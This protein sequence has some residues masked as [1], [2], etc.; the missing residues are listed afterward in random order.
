MFISGHVSSELRSLTRRSFKSLFKP[1]TKTSYSNL[2]YKQYY[3]FSNDNK[4]ND[5]NELDPKNYNQIY[6]GGFESFAAKRRA[7]AKYIEKMKEK[8]FDVSIFAEGPSDIVVDFELFMLCEEKDSQLAEALM[9]YYKISFKRNQSFVMGEIMKNKVSVQ[10]KIPINDMKFPML[11]VRISL[12][13][14]KYLFGSQEILKYLTKNN[15]IFEP[16]HLTQS[17]RAAQ[18]IEFLRKDFEKNLDALFW[19]PVLTY[20]N[21]FKT[22]PENYRFGTRSFFLIRVIRKTFTKVFFNIFKNFGKRIKNKELYKSSREN[23]MKNLKEWSDRIGDKPFHGGE[24]PD[25]ADFEMFA[26]IKAKLNSQYF[27]KFLENK[28]PDRVY[29]WLLRM[30]MNCRFEPGR[31]ILPDS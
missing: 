15:F 14:A 22:A 29:R 2:Y 24:Q 17:A 8:A 10:E 31:M 3:N 9:N 11:R 18:S 4:N 23:V 25:E 30:Q 16:K 1:K 6:V 28:G 12:E 13:P 26:I 20:Q 5:K 21:L 7:H 19:S 27:E